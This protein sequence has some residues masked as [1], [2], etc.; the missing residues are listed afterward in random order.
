MVTP[1]S[2]AHPASAAATDGAA[3]AVVDD[4]T[5]QRLS[6]ANNAELQAA[7]HEHLPTLLTE[8]F[9]EAAARLQLFFLPQTMNAI[10]SG[11]FAQVYKAQYTD[12]RQRKRE[13]ICAVKRPFE[14]SEAQE[15]LLVDA[16]MQRQLAPHPYIVDFVA[17]VPE[18][19][20]VTAASFAYGN[21]EQNVL[22]VQHYYANGNL[23]DWAQLSREQIGR[24][25]WLRWARQLCLA[26][27]H[28]HARH[29]V[30]H[31]LKPQ[32]VLISDDLDLKLSDFGNALFVDAAGGPLHDALGRG[33]DGTFFHKREKKKKADDECRL[34][35]ARDHVAAF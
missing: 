34:Y 7:L 16:V 21:A 5:V 2:S 9:E 30:H 32:N 29:I 20:E 4:T 25:M 15:A 23:W 22:L 18:P 24:R 12:L 35:C 11:R 17:V 6:I 26:V 3:T 14:E 33:T 31:D 1:P 8:F 13:T 10:G 28:V 27:D 19:D